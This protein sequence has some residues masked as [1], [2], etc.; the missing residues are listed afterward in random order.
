MNQTITSLLL[1]I[2]LALSAVAG[3]SETNTVITQQTEPTQLAPGPAPAS[4]TTTTLGTNSAE[5][6]RLLKAWRVS[7]AQTPRPKGCFEA[8]Y[9]SKEWREVPSANPPLIPMLPRRGPTPLT[10][11][12]GNDVAA[13]APS[14]LISFA[15]G[16]FDSVSGVT[17]ESGQVGGTG[18]PVANAYTLQLNTDFFPSTVGGA[19][20][21]EGWEQFVFENDGGSSPNSYVYIQYW[22]INYGS[23]S[24]G[25]GWYQYGDDWFRNSTNSS[26]PPSQPI[27]NLAA[28]SLGG[29]ITASGDS[30]LFYAGNSMYTATGDNSVHAASGWNAAEFGVFGDGGGGEANFNNGST[31]DI[32]T[33]IIY[34]GFAPPS[35]V[36]EGFTGEMNNL[37][38]G[39][40]AP[41]APG[42]ENGPALLVTLSSAGN[43]TATCGAATAVAET[44]WVDFNTGQN[45]PAGKGT[46]DAPVLTLA[47]AVN[48][49]PTGGNVWIRTAGSSSETVPLTITKALTINA[50]SGPGTVGH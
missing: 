8:T 13:Q 32:R 40:T 28:L 2:M 24:P 15:I 45:P 5:Q 31:I 43:A 9:P 42:P 48:G 29:T 18:P 34:G 49:V 17:S 33:E 10:V 22:L 1:S 25:S 3:G 47:E 16:S 35:C 27:G 38:F 23:I 14:G 21:C 20:G 7:M 39:P 46:Y 12:N 44:Y 37:N 11:G 6:A 36:A 50:Y 4:A 30:Y 26:S 19:P 41:S